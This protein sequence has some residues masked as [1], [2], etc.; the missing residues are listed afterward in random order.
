MAKPRQWQRGALQR[1]GWRTL[2][3]RRKA[4]GQ[5]L[6]GLVKIIDVV[7]N[8]RRAQNFPMTLIRITGSQLHAARVMAGLS[9]ESLADR[10]GLCCHSIRSWENSSHGIPGATYSHLCRAVDVLENEGTRFSGDGV[11]VFSG[12]SPD[13]LMEAV[14][15]Q[16]SRTIARI[17]ISTVTPA[18][19]TRGMSRS[20][21]LRG[22][23]NGSPLG[24]EVTSTSAASQHADR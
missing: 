21:N 18:Y 6:G 16:S 3:P 9:R 23:Y 13:Y 19:P 12:D 4:R 10:A 8:Q 1:R 17:Y 24:C 7:R 11:S 2:C 20:P 22:S 5:R 14:P 15:S